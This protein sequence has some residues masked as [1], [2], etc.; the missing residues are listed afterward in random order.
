[1]QIPLISWPPRRFAPTPQRLLFNPSDVKKTYI[2]PPLVSTETTPKRSEHKVESTAHVPTV[3]FNLTTRHVY[4][5]K[6]L[7]R[8]RHGGGSNPLRSL[9]KRS[10]SFA[11]RITSC[12]QSGGITPWR[13]HGCLIG[14]RPDEIRM[15]Y[16]KYFCAN[17]GSYFVE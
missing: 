2:Q 8:G 11:C 4:A 9:I 7:F 15:K 17:I 1:M 13:F 16:N 12:A 3:E 10:T 14:F 5:D 6:H